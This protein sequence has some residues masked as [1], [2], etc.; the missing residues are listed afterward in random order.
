MASRPTAR[1]RSGISYAPGAVAWIVLV[2][3]LVVTTSAGFM[4]SNQA[5][6]D[7][8]RGFE[9]DAKFVTGAITKQVRAIEGLLNNAPEQFPPSQPLDAQE[10]NAYVTNGNNANGGNLFF[11]SVLATRVPER[12]VG[13]LMV[14]VD[15]VY[16]LI[17][18]LVGQ[19][20][21]A[22]VLGDDVYQPPKTGTITATSRIRTENIP[23]VTPAGILVA[24][25][26]ALERP[27]PVDKGWFVILFRP[28][29]LAANAGPIDD[30]GLGVTIDDVTPGNPATRLATFPA[31]EPR[32]PK[33]AFTETI[34]AGDRLWRLRVVTLPS[35]VALNQP[36]V[37]MGFVIGVGV[38]G[39]L[40][41]FGLAWVSA[42][43]VRRHGYSSS[44]THAATHDALTGLPNRTLVLD[45]LSQALARCRRSDTCAAVLFVDID[46]FK[47]LND[48]YGHEA[49]D[50]AL[51]EIGER[52]HGALRE[53]D[54]VGRIG[55]D[56]FVVIAEESTTREAAEEV[57]TRVIAI[58]SIPLILSEVRAQVGASVGIVLASGSEPA[59]NV[60]RAADSAM[61]E[62][63]QRGRNR[64]HVYDED[65]KTRDSARVRMERDLE[66]AILRGELELHYQPIFDSKRLDCGGL[67][68]L[69]RWRHPALGLLHPHEFLPLA[70][71][72]GLLVGIDRW[73]FSEVC[74]RSMEWEAIG[75]SRRIWCNVS[76]SWFAR[77][78]FLDELVD[79]ATTLGADPARI[80]LEFDED[81]LSGDIRRT[82]EVLA[83][84]R[85]LGYAVVIDDFGAGASSIATL[86][87]LELD[88]L[89]LD[90]SLVI[91]LS[92][93]DDADTIAGA[94]C[95]LARGLQLAVVAEGVE[96]A[97][98]L[99]AL[100]RFG[101][102]FVQG[103]LFS[104]AVPADLAANWLRTG[105]AGDPTAS[106]DGGATVSLIDPAD[107][108]GPDVPVR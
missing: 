67:E 75:P 48:V 27:A 81:V 41:L 71:R 14:T 1:T 5:K 33:F 11:A 23:I 51:V 69:I 56:E 31:Q 77:D 24:M 15:G 101:C 53:T 98:Q 74:K 100:R 36:S 85:A 18:G 8:R 37:S 34:S 68:A 102:E 54:T 93:S 90:R 96:R 99:A 35:Y 26:R 50:R 91:P 17:A 46:G 59:E 89:K 105:G 106:P 21:E 70:K 62:A 2:I 104:A 64:Y 97:D 30:R 92:V 79:I 19:Q 40:L 52:L 42:I 22:S 28:Q 63:K 55:G 39:T 60:L 94:M 6:T 10:F 76:L 66:T 25:T 9:R 107:T 84:A 16:P 86:R 4:A 32:D 87:D 80:A 43:A 7:T 95:S 78:K 65:L 38:A 82:S 12:S 20:L 49:G 83:E 29:S 73:V 58:L 45:R 61:Y 108:P 3:G 13:P 44:L 47:A 72:R 57:A 88:A 103:Y